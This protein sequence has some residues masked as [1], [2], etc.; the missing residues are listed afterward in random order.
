MNEKIDKLQQDIS[1]SDE[2]KPC[3]IDID[4]VESQS[5]KVMRLLHGNNTT[6]VLHTQYYYF[7]FKEPIYIHKIKFFPEENTNLL[8]LE[9]IITN[10]KGKESTI[11]FTKKEDVI[12][13]PKEIIKEFKIKPKKK[14]LHKTKLKNIELVGFLVEELN[15]IKDKV[16]EVGDYKVELQEKLDE[17]VQKNNEYNGKEDRIDELNKEIPGLE[18]KKIKYEYAIKELRNTRVGLKENNQILKDS[19]SQL[20]EESESLNKKIPEQKTELKKLIENKNIFSTEMTEY[21]KQ[22]DNHMATYFVL[23]VIPWLLIGCISYLVFNRTADLSTIYNSLDGEVNVFAIFWTRL[24]FALITISILFIAYEISKML[25]Q[26]MMKI[27][28]QKRIFAKIGIVAKDVADSSILELQ[29]L[30]DGERFE[31]RTKLKM[32]L[33]KAHL[34]NDIGEEYEYEIKTSL[35]ERFSH[36]FKKRSK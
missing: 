2:I 34:S 16:E 35:L 24:P 4:L 6:E 26:N 36:L 12:I 3:I 25:I 8:G 23:S 22:A 14:F 7:K 11:K 27:Q 32:D 33:L 5:G 20:K 18:S 13:S 1:N 21:I 29:D 19:T 28:S 9:I 30:T 17:L 31:L 10:L 15:S